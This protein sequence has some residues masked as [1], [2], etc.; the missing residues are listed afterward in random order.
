M[1]VSASSTL[2]KIEEVNCLGP[3]SWQTSQTALFYNTSLYFFY[4]YT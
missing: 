3:F 1:H 2:I 4:Y